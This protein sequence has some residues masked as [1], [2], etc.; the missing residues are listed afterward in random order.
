MNSGNGYAMP[1]PSTSTA[2]KRVAADLTQQIH[3]NHK[4]PKRDMNDNIVADNHLIN[5]NFGFDRNLTLV[6][7]SLNNLTTNGHQLDDHFG[8]GLSDDELNDVLSQVAEHHQPVHQIHQ[9]RFHSTTAAANGRNPSQLSTQFIRMA[10]QV[11]ST[12]ETQNNGSSGQTNGHNNG[13]GIASAE[14]NEGRIKILES[15]N[16]K[17]SE[18]LANYKSQVIQTKR[19]VVDVRTEYKQ[20]IGDINRKHESEMLFTKSELQ[21]CQQ[22]NEKLQTFIDSK[23]FADGNKVEFVSNFLKNRN[24]SQT[25]SQLKMQEFYG[26]L[27]TQPLSTQQMSGSA[28]GS[29]PDRNVF[30]TPNSIRMSQSYLSSTPTEIP[31]TQ[32]PYHF[33]L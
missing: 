6:T 21:L 5:T 12:D 26:P 24:H 7:N 23:S 16:Q 31:A 3:D 1:P 32:S 20:Q 30:K 19:Q 4:R 10:D 28:I 11:M 13:G 14:A 33:Y 29:T 15:R 9:I 25:F 18:E 27:P 2:A 8:D 17:L 22:M